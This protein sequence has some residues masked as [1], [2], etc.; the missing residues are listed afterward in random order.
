MPP[1]VLEHKEKKNTLEVTAAIKDVNTYFFQLLLS[2]P[3]LKHSK[4]PAFFQP[5]PVLAEG[6]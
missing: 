5:W 4:T 2:D 3:Y 6:K 1:P